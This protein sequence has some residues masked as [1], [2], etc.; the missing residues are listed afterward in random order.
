[1]KKET[2]LKWL[3]WLFPAVFQ[4]S[5]IYKT[6][7]PTYILYLAVFFCY[8]IMIKKNRHLERNLYYMILVIIGVYL[9]IPLLSRYAE[10]QTITYSMYILLFF[11]DSYICGITMSNSDDKI[12]FL[13]G[14]LV[15][16]SSILGMQLIKNKSGYSLSAFMT[17]FSGERHGR[18]Y[19]GYSHPNFA[20]MFL[21]MET[22]LIYL[23]IRG[24]SRKSYRILLSCIEL[25]VLITI[26]MTGSRGA[27]YC[28]ILFY[29]FEFIRKLSDL[30]PRIK[31]ITY[32]IL[33]I[34]FIYTCINMYGDSV[35]ENSSGRYDLLWENFEFLNDSGTLLLGNGGLP[36]SSKISGISFS[37]NWYMTTII[38]VGLFGFIFLIIL[39]TVFFLNLLKKE[40]DNISISILSI[41]LM[42]IAYSFSENMFFVPGVGISWLSW[43][44]IMYKRYIFID[45]EVQFNYEK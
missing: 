43:S 24:E 7:L 13:K 39:F 4:I 34:I 22:I 15:S 37:D 19:F 28:T 21:I 44:L 35:I 3:I 29:S 2:L 27:L 32:F 20:G 26:C 17:V 5:N 41:V 42:L 23:V 30:F 1:M 11:L 45:N 16:N 10:F 33:I 25:G 14:W 8:F 36:I 38:N 31:K 18:S 12:S 6:T 40:N 9:L